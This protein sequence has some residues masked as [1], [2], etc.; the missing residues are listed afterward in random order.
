M[1]SAPLA[2]PDAALSVSV[3]GSA[4]CCA[5]HESGVYRETEDAARAGNLT[6]GSRLSFVRRAVNEL[7]FAFQGALPARPCAAERAFLTEQV[8]DK[9]TPPASEMQTA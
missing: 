7:F 4:G 3:F 2:A 5:C 1:P 8:F 6:A 9:L